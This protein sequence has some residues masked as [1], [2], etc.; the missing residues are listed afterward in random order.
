MV[1]ISIEHENSKVAQN[2]C[3]AVED[4]ADFCMQNNIES[5]AA[6]NAMIVIVI[7]NFRNWQSSEKE[8]LDTLRKAWRHYSIDEKVNRTNSG[9]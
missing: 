3:D 5:K 7:S 6:L 2:I 4:I 1:K 8:F 9:N